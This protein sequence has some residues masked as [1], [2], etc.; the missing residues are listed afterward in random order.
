MTK[1]INPAT[2]GRIDP[3]NWREYPEHYT[4]SLWPAKLPSKPA[5]YGSNDF[6]G[7]THPEIIKVALTRYTKPGDLV[8][9]CFGGSGTTLDVCAEYQNPCIANDVTPTRNDIIKADS[10]DWRPDQPVDLVICHPPYMNIVNYQD[11]WL[12][13]PSLSHYLAGMMNVFDNIH[14][15][16]KDWHVLVL[17]V[18][19]VYN[20][21]ETVCLDYH[22][23][24]LLAG[25]RLLG[26]V[27]RPYGETKGGATSGKKNENLWRYRRLKYGIWQLDQDVVLFLQKLPQV[28]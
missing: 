21:Q 3:A 17:I 15:A 8:W 10:M 2:L 9:D 1:I 7:R 6:P 26:R 12:S 4:T 13:T 20:N 19:V 25:Y 5:D 23:H 22:L 16:L 11:G 24:D 28:Y 18:G 27:V 14:I